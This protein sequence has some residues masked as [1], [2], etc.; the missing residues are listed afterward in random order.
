[1]ILTQITSIFHQHLTPASHIRDPSAPDCLTL[2]VCVCVWGTE[3]E[4]SCK[5]RLQAD[6]EMP[7]H[8]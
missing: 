4:D 6:A 5:G 1:M 7:F 8:L 3:E 2:C